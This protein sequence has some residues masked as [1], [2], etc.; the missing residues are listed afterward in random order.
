MT[1]TYLQW[2]WWAVLGS[3]FLPLLIPFCT[4]SSYVSDKPWLA[5]LVAGFFIL[6]AYITNF[7][8]KSKLLPKLLT[9]VETAAEQQV[10]FL[11]A[12]PDKYVAPAIFLSAAIGLYLELAV[13]RWQGT[14]TIFFSFYKN[15]GLLACFAGLG[16]GFS[17][18][19]QKANPLLC[20][21][22][23][24]LWQFLLLTFI[25][26]GMPFYLTQSILAMPISEQVSVGASVA[27][28]VPEFAMIYFLMAVVFLLTSLCFIPVGQ[29]CGN[30]M[31]RQAPLKSYSANLLGSLIGVVLIIGLSY[32]WTP[33]VVWFALV[34]LGLLAFFVYNIRIFSF[35]VVAFGLTM[36]VLAW[37]VSFGSELVYSP[38]QLLERSAGPNGIN[39][40]SAAGAYYQRIYDFS[41]KG[42]GVYPDF[43]NAADYYDL[44]Y[45]LIPNVQNVAIVGAGAGNDVA[46]ALRAGAKHVDAIEIDPAIQSFGKMFHP[47]QPY[48]D[49]RVNAIINDA[50]AFLGD[51]KDSYDMIVF[52]VLDSHTLSSHM[53]S[54]RLDSYVYTVESLKAVRKHLNDKGVV[55]LSFAVMSPEIAK[56][57]YLMISQ[58]FDNHP[59]VCIH[60]HFE[61]GG[62][63]PNKK[64]FQT[65]AYTFMQSKNGDLQISPQLIAGLGFDDYGAKLAD[66]EV[67]ADVST[68]DWPF[69]YM[70]RRIFPVSFLPMF[71]I[72]LLMSWLL[73][74]TLQGFQ[75]GFNYLPYFFLGSGF[76]LIETKA[77]TELGLQ[78]GNTW[79]IIGIVI[80]AIMV[81]AFFANLAVE[82]FKW[83]NTKLAFVFLLGAILAG[84]L[85]SASGGFG[86]STGG[87]IATTL[88]LTSPLFFSGIVFSTMISKCKD[89]SSAMAMNLMGAILGGFLEYNAMYFGYR[90]LYLLALI[91]YGLAFLST[92]MSGGSR[93][94]AEVAAT[95][96]E[97]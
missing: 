85:V 25:S 83:T 92:F 34:F 5:V 33:P 47:E 97:A 37:P 35:S 68:D 28:K 58:A 90:A 44:P 52:G 79:S 64:G 32:F 38:Y 63:A 22:P 95:S 49:Q 2:L 30:L 1:R 66:P 13:I 56:K 40:I 73:I 43:K 48:Q 77:I 67:V 86:A 91:I 31:L 53:S 24:L 3:I 59:P 27:T 7:F 61:R 46:A 80:S 78:F 41:A 60:T 20:T 39:L 10:S 16:I 26:R 4:L 75:G 17:L 11:A 87:K 14:A 96:A 19:K 74:S 15:F 29:L 36:I 69:F 62:F 8:F 42:R 81:M 12:L 54:L 51:T 71:G 70:P 57:L 21:I 94:T 9:I 23:C 76:M 55:C 45:K 88:L 84:Y 18:A 82:R 72:V 50:R 6:L 93:G 65:G 89:I